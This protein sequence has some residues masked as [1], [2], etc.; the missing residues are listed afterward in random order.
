MKRTWKELYALGKA[1]LDRKEYD[2][3]LQYFEE[4]L[5]VKE[6]FADVHNHLGFIYHE[7]GKYKDAT[8]SFR[9]ALVINPRYTEALLNLS[10]TYFD[11]GE[12]KKAM[13]VYSKA[14]SECKSEPS[15]P[16]DPNVRGKLANKHAELGTLYQ[17]LGFFKKA[18]NEFRNALELRPNLIDIKVLLGTAYR[19]M[20]DLP[21]AIKELEEAK[22]IKA[23]YPQA[24]INLG[25][26]YYT[27]GKTSEAAREWGD[28]LH[29]NPGEKK[30]EMYLR[31]VEKR[32]NSTH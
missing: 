24:G 22:S 19:D 9:R 12:Y 21:R 15:P 29:H 8:E 7:M 13:E 14:K 23:D 32:N 20:G 11:I 6:G 3:S 28:V 27:M 26:T 1:S 30:A 18:I 31:L 10:V 25:I 17:N 2:K 5:A 16:L 4:L